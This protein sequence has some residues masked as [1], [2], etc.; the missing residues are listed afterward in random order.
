MSSRAGSVRVSLK[1]V[2]AGARLCLGTATAA[3][4]RYAWTGGTT[5]NNPREKPV[6]RSRV[7]YKLVR[8]SFYMFA[9]VLLAA[10]SIIFSACRRTC[11]EDNAATTNPSL[12]R[13]PIST[14]RSQQVVRQSEPDNKQAVSQQAGH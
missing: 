7:P 4:A 14:R 3:Q 1:C 10:S 13:R 11:L 9:S 5:Q 12:G 2:Q 8:P 6:C